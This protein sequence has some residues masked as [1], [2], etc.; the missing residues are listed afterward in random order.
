MTR[1]KIAW[2]TKSAALP[3]EKTSRAGM[4]SWHEFKKGWKHIGKGGPQKDQ[5]H[6]FLNSFSISRSPS[7]KANLEQTTV[8]LHRTRE[9]LAS[10][11]V[12]RYSMLLIDVRVSQ[13]LPSGTSIFRISSFGLLVF[14]LAEKYPISTQESVFT[15]FRRI[16]RFCNELH[17]RAFASTHVALETGRVTKWLTGKGYGFITGSNNRQYFVHSNE[18]NVEEGGFKSLT[19]GQEVM[20][21]PVEEAPNKFKAVN[22]RALNGSLLPGGPL[23]SREGGDRSSGYG[24][25]GFDNE[26]GGQ[27]DGGYQPRGDGGG[28]RGRGRSGYDR[29]YR[30]SRDYNQRGD[31]NAKNRELDDVWLTS[32]SQP[33]VSHVPFLSQGLRNGT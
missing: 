28:Y 25:S 26:S 3:D 16:G 27:Q 31:L 15:M 10:G 17:I 13:A 7:P 8:F 14:L 33:P 20:F 29:R 2:E 21:D 30:G 4:Y 32:C 11:F 6:S 23:L 18:L 22:V 12:H 19:N 1:K 9:T 24:R 5:Y